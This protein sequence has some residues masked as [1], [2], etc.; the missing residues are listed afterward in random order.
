MFSDHIKNIIFVSVLALIVLTIQ[1]CKPEITE[2]ELN[3]NYIS[4]VIEYVYA[5]GQ[6]AKLVKLSDINNF[7]GDPKDKTGWLYL[8]SFGGYVIAGFA[9]DVTNVEGADFE[10][11]SYG[12][13][14][15]P[16]VVSVMADENADGKPN[17]K[18]YELKGN[19]FENSKRNYWVRY[20]KAATT[21]S[22][23]R[24]KDSEGVQGEL[25]SGYGATNSANW[26]WSQT[27]T[28][29]ITL[30]GTR[31]PNAYENNPVDG[32]QYW[33][34]PSSRFT[35]GYAE[36]P[37]GTDFDLVTKSNKLDISN[38][39][40]SLGNSVNLTKIRFLKI[41]S[42]VLQ[43]AGWT[44]EVSPEVRGAKGFN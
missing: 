44:N 24:W 30:K 12:N 36:N 22:N 6:H 33:T 38:A 23:I 18:W 31:L 3:S 21:S 19:Q 16:A 17:E 42:S 2:E 8:G 34:V 37:Y 7:I 28:D 27:L 41:Q 20:Y 43:Q 14:P 25:I 32:E 39:V 40:D 29:S 10:I 15:E 5:P 9:T 1:S 26:W 13:S 35:W 11:Y 4:E